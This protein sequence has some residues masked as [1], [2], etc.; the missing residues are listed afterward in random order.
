LVHE[1]SLSETSERNEAI[2]S[3]NPGL[4]FVS[5]AVFA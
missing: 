3:D 4:F 5:L 2:Y 1:L